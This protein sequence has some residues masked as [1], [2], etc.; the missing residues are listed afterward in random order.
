[1]SKNRIYLWVIGIEVVVGAV[2]TI[3]GLAIDFAI[4]DPPA[5][6]PSF[7]FPLIMMLAMCFS[8]GIVVL[9]IVIFA[10][11]SLILK[12]VDSFKSK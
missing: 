10:L 3:G 4:Y 6:K 8:V 5:D 11:H 7:M 2:L 1:M 9:T 12:L